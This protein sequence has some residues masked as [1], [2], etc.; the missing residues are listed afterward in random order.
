M[1][2]EVRDGG[3]QA[4]TGK[5]VIILLIFKNSEEKQLNS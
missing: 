3:G 2:R 1:C 5:L 4:M